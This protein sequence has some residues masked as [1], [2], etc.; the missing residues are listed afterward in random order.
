[1]NKYRFQLIRK[2]MLDVTHIKSFGLGIPA[3]N[4]VRNR[5]YYILDDIYFYFYTDGCK[6]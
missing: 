4:E 5:I 3:I 1:M 6:I 2:C